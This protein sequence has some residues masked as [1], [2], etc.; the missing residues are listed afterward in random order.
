MFA[1]TLITLALLLIG[2][3]LYNT[4]TLTEQANTNNKEMNKT[5][6][7]LSTKEDD[8]YKSQLQ[9]I[10]INQ[11]TAQLS[12]YSKDITA[13]AMSNSNLLILWSSG[14]TLFTI[15]FV[16][17]GF[18]EF[19]YKMQDASRMLGQMNNAKKNIKESLDKISSYE[20]DFKEGLSQIDQNKEQLS[21]AIDHVDNVLSKVEAI[22]VQM[23]E[24]STISHFN[25]KIQ[26]ILNNRNSYANKIEELSTILKEINSDKQLKNEQWQELSEKCNGY[27]GQLSE[28]NRNYKAAVVFYDNVIRLSQKP[29][30][31][32]FWRANAYTQLRQHRNAIIDYNQI[33][34]TNPENA[35]AYYLRGC[36]YLL[37]EE[38]EKAFADLSNSIEISA[39]YAPAYNKR[40][41]TYRL[42][43]YDKAIAD[44]DKAIRIDPSLADALFNKGKLYLALENQKEA[45]IYLTQALDIDPKN[46][47]ARRI[48]A[49]CLTV[50]K[51]YEK[52]AADYTLLLENGINDSETYLQRAKLYDN[53]GKQAKSLSDYNES[54]RLD[55]KN[56]DAYISRGMLYYMESQ[57]EEALADLNRYLALEPNAKGNTDILSIIEEIHD[58]IE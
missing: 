21:N 34:Q 50:S 7:Q 1:A 13:T 26:G 5:F 53:L 15:G 4:H 36:A 38:N 33:L 30:S 24:S 14:I 9:N 3:A 44:F 55:K 29:T 58:E 22:G 27:L 46:N 16:F 42:E 31:A 6:Q 17:I 23:H 39:E 57:F 11:A 28:S 12:Q 35:K 47:D 25:L 48:R 32:H 43:D 2:T 45:I 56:K 8:S 52:A 20:S 40:G 54:I 10:L 41:E 18:I 51:E 49:T 19:K 37:V